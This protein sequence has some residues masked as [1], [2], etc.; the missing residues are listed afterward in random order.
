MLLAAPLLA[1]TPVH[2]EK[3][4]TG[5]NRQANWYYLR[6]DGAPKHEPI[7]DVDLHEA[8]AGFEI[9]G[10]YRVIGDPSLLHCQ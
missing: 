2:T 3:T 7:L 5:R 8:V 4:K 10:N 6:V 1:A 9:G